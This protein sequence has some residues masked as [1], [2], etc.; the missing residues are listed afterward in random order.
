M[1]HFVEALKK[2]ECYPHRCEPALF[3]VELKGVFVGPDKIKLS[4]YI[5]YCHN[6]PFF[7][8][9]NGLCQWKEK[10]AMFKP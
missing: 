6:V 9:T 10:I 5:Y 2:G 4:V 3:D 8:W 7:K 1:N